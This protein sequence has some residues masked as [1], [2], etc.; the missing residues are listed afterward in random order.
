[1]LLKLPY[2][3]WQKW[4]GW[5]AV[6]IECI[7]LALFFFYRARYKVGPELSKKVQFGYGLFMLGYAGCRILFI[8]SDMERD[9]NDISRLY[10]QLVISGY[11]CMIVSLLWLAHVIERNIM[12]SKKKF[13]TRLFITLLVITGVML[14]VSSIYYNSELVITLTRYFVYSISFIAGLVV[15]IFYL[16][17]VIKTTGIVRIN[18]LLNLFGLIL[19]FIGTTMD[20]EIFYLLFPIFI[21]PIITAS[22]FIVFT[23]SQWR[24]A[25]L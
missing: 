20:S 13:T 22:G 3:V 18:F 17:M 14:A 24:S 1:M 9:L 6:I 2:D 25:Q 4:P 5:I 7:L 15:F 8:F 11:I 10:T 23:L 21:P 12:Q 16:N 19:I